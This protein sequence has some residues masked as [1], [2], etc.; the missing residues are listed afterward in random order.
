MDAETRRI[1]ETGDPLA[2]WQRDIIGNAAR[3]HI[4]LRDAVRLRHDAELL[5]ELAATLRRLSHDTT[6]DQ[7][8]LLNQARSAIKATDMA[9]RN[10]AVPAGRKS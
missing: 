5:I 10:G 8:R 4:P 3:L 1:I 9:I 6:T 2:R 7:W